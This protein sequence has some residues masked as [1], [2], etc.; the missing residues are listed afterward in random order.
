MTASTVPTRVL[1]CESSADGTIGGSHYCLLY[2]IQHLDRSRFEPLAI[3]YEPHALLARF[4][5]TTE[6]IVH[7][8]D[9]PVQWGRSGVLRPFARAMNLLKFGGAVISHVA[10]L[11]RHRIGLLHL[12][13]SITRHQD[14]M[15]A[16]RLAGVPCIVHE[17]GLS[18]SYSAR[19]RAHARDVDLIIPM[20]AWIRD[21]MIAQGIDGR[22]IRVMYDGLDPA[23]VTV[24][25]SAEEMRTTWQVPAGAPV[26]GIVG[27]IRPWKG[28]ETVARAVVE[29]AR[30]V[31]DVVC[32]FVGATTPDDEAYLAGMKSLLAAAGC[33]RNVRFTGYQ[34]DVPNFINMMEVL[35][36]ASVDPEPF[37][38]VVLEGMA[39]RKPVIGSRA[40]GPVEMILEGETGFTFPPGD[41]GEL[42]ARVLELLGDRERR[43][44]MGG[45]GYDRLINEFTMSR[46]MENI[47]ATYQAVLARRPVPPGIGLPPTATRPVQPAS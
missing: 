36:H 28:Q 37:G 41:A 45:R 13:N 30:T 16:A 34:K 44:R 4:Q 23:S 43:G 14:W 10:L 40:G 1:Y 31:P 2:L 8:R 38:M 25:R 15:L 27:N 42:A 26:I 39:Q 24:T 3:F 19:D 9:T 20:S 17:R 47:H 33:E 18:E 32:F 5:A 12:N 11:R 6:T 21:H 35:I 46:Y 29:I 7:A 22:N